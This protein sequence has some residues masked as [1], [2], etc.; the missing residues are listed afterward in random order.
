MSAEKDNT[1][2]NLIIA[3][4]IVAALAVTLRYF[5]VKDKN[6]TMDTITVVDK[7]TGNER[8]WLVRKYLKKSDGYVQFRTLDGKIVTLDGSKITEE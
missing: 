1:L 7:E 2:T 3:L 4:W 5:Y 8:A 6:S